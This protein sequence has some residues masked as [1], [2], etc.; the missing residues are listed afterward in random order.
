M[1][2]KSIIMT[3][4]NKSLES[5]SVKLLSSKYSNNPLTLFLPLHCPFPLPLISLSL[6]CDVY[7]IVITAELKYCVWCH[8]DLS[9]VKSMANPS[10]E[11]IAKSVQSHL[12]PWSMLSQHKLQVISD[13]TAEM[14]ND[15][16]HS[17]HPN[18]RLPPEAPDIKNHS[19]FILVMFYQSSCTMGSKFI[20][21]NSVECLLFL[22]GLNHY[23]LNGQKW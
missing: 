3:Q 22:S 16:R 6:Y 11:E 14:S 4:K 13:E 20:M 10:P 17:R 15:G 18:Q 23:F 1:T 21:K 2:H 7:L 5:N 9:F 8:R 12:R 19:Q